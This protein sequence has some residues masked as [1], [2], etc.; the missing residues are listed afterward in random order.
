VSPYSWQCIAI[1]LAEQTNKN[2]INNNKAGDSFSDFKAK[3]MTSNQD[4]LTFLQ[5]AQEAQAKEKDEDKKTRARERQEDRDNIMA[6]IKT[7]VQKEVKAAVKEVE[8]RL[9]LQ[10]KVNEELSRQL[11]SLVKNMEALQASVNDQKAFPA[12]PVPRNHH[13]SDMGLGESCGRGDRVVTGGRVTEGS[14]EDCNRRIE[15]MCAAGRRVVGFSPIEPRMLD[16]QI[17]SYGARNLEEAMLMEIKSYL[18]CEMKVQPSE[19]E[20][21]DIVRIFHP[22]KENWNVLYVEFA[23]EY[24]VDKLFSYTRGM[25][26]QDHRV[27]RWYPRQMYDR[28]RAVESIAYEIRKKLSHK[29]RVKIGRND[30]ELSTR[31]TGSAVW[32]RQALPDNLPKFDL[33]SFSGPATSSPPPGRPGRS[34][35]YPTLPSSDMEL[36]EASVGRQSE[37]IERE[38]S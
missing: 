27:V 22:A 30:I 1:G 25:V 3:T 36:G 2:F 23:N 4:I 29:T 32:K 7:G 9:G 24:Q 31:E 15:E 6:M 34:L 28:Y 11:N 33:D 21:L 35:I 14:T 13:I 8:E 12:L 10:E 37:Q 20:K 26:K 5:A 17:Q 38:S 18:K 16:L 19:I